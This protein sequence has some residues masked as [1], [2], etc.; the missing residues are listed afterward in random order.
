MVAG[1]E[2][3]GKSRLSAVEPVLYILEHADKPDKL[4]WIVGGIYEMAKPEFGYA[5]ADLQ[6]LGLVDK[7]YLPRL[8]SQEAHGPGYRMVTKSSDDV[9]RIAAEAPDFVLMCEAAQQ[10]LE[11]F[12]RLRGRVAEK[13][14]YLIASGTFEG[15]LGWYP[16]RW[17]R[18]Q[19]D[20]PDNGVSFSMPTWSNIYIYP[21]GLGDPEIKALKATYPPAMFQERFGA[22][23]CPPSTL[24]FPE[25]RWDVHTQEDIVDDWENFDGE[26][27]IAVDPGYNN[28]YAV[29]AI[30]RTD[31]MIRVVDEIYQKFTLGEHIIRMAQGSRWWR[32]VRGGVIDVTGRKHEAQ[33]SQIEIW[34]ELTGLH[35]RSQFVPIEDGISRYRSF[36]DNPGYGVEAD[37]IGTPLLGPRIIYDRRCTNSIVEHGKYKYRDV[38]ENRSTAG[39]EKPIDANNHALKAM[40]YY[41]VD[42]FGYVPTLRGIA[43]QYL[44]KFPRRRRVPV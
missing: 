5:F 37:Q 25:F 30:W 9:L 31:D 24:V 8:G 13:R 10:T 28:P 27:E 2:R 34:E 11:T 44:P 26:I 4:I 43:S 17:R 29:L 3:A 33:K 36:L 7:S 38:R 18:W 35:L 1:G 21:G 40:S 14:G 12:L 39:M 15:S 23:P 32:H 41:L 20:N 22:V 42:V 19:H 6:K 16:E